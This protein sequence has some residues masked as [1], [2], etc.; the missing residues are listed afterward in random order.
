VRFRLT[1]RET[2]FYPMFAQAADNLVVA[3][4]LLDE[5][6]STEANG[7]LAERMRDVEH[8]GDEVTHLIMRR[9]NS[10]FVT[11]FDRADI[12]T[13]ASRLDD[14]LDAMDEAVDFVVLYKLWNL[15]AEVADQVGVLQRMAELTA[16]AMPRLR[17]LKDLD[18]F[19]IEINRLENDAD[20][21]YRRLLAKL[22][23]GEYDAL[24]VLKL[25]DVVDAL[26]EAADA[27][28]HVANT[29][30]TIVLKES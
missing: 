22:F 7:A 8:Q 13:L 19:W 17:T 15:P 11:P 29:V 4:K 10:T 23:G 24:T 14:V 26:E 21:L 18:D 3:A 25:K 16:Q 27:F 2:S 28:E 30:E 12:Y 5:L 6:F 20:R 9:L 1:P